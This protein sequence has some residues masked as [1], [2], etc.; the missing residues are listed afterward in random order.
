LANIR[1]IFEN[2][3]EPRGRKFEKRLLHGHFSKIAQIRYQGET[4]SVHLRQHGGRIWRTGRRENHAIA[5]RRRFPYLGPIVIIWDPAVPHSAIAV[6]TA[7]SRDEILAVGGSVSWVVAEKQARRREFLVCIRNARG[8]DFHDHEPHGTAFLVGRISGLKPYGHD[9]KG[10]PRFIIEIS[11]HALI[12]HPEAWGEWRNPVKY[13][14]LEELGIDPKKL[15]FKPTTATKEPPPPPAPDRS[16]TGALT[17]AEAKAGLALQFGV[18]PE[19]IEIL[20]KG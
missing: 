20:I 16:K 9:K 2:N 7:D 15:K 5:R 11:D 4:V 13:T 14:T 3:S 12:D 6:F 19:G 8:V 1:V 10:M 17:I 18:P